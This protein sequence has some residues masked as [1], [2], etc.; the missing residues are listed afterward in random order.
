MKG[1]QVALNYIF[2]KYITEHNISIFYALF[3]PSIIMTYKHNNFFR[4]NVLKAK[5]NIS[6]GIGYPDWKLTIYLFISWLIIFFV[7]IRGVKSSGKVAYFL[8][9]FPYVIMF[10]L[11]GRAVTL[12]GAVNGIIYFIT[13][14]WDQLL[15][16]KV[17]LN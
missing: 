17:R 15:L 13:P 1:Q 10:T 7:I 5:Q 6:D 4:I 11:L 14:K 9:I 12:E 2:C 3:F 8:A 16:A